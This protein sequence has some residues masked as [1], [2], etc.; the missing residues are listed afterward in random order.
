MLTALR[1]LIARVRAVVHRSAADRDFEQEL[2]AHVEMLT[3]DNVARGMTPE[4]A[5]T[6]ARLRVGSASSLAMQHRDARGLPWLEDLMQDLAFAG[7]L[8]ARD[9][10]FSAAAIVVIALGIGA[11]AVGF[12]IVNAAFF[13][14]FGFVRADQLHIISW[15]PDRGRRLPSSYADLLDWRSQSRSFSAIGAYQFEALNISDDHAPPQQTQGAYVTANLF[16]VL[17]EQPV[18]GRGFAAGEDQRGADRVALIS[19]ELWANRYGRDP[20]VIGRALRV[21]GV[22]TTIVGVMRD[23]M[24]FPDNSELWVTL[25]PTDAQLARDARRLGVVGRLKDG[26]SERQAE[27]EIDAIARRIMAAYPDQTKGMVGG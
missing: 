6:A 4:A 20:G 17:R 11:N 9:R 26:A 18:L 25:I 23:G 27:T 14:G 12:T 13:R 2:Q 21:S 10:S 22:A 16:E 1:H 7:R 5:R 19:D 3:D 24:K 8:M 15:R